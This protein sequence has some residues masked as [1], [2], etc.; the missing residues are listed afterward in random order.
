L[1][2]YTTLTETKQLYYFFTDEIQRELRLMK[3]DEAREIE[4]SYLK[5]KEKLLKNKN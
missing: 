4:I 2:F 1:A 5:K 3:S